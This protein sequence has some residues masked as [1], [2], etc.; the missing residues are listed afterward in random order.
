M[1]FGVE[2]QDIL[3]VSHKFRA[4]LGE[5]APLL[6]LPR[7]ESVFLRRFRIPSWDME[8]ASPN[9]TTFPANRRKVQ[10]LC[11]SGAGRHLQD[12]AGA[13][14]QDFAHRMRWLVR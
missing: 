8:D 11:P 14:M 9:S 13:Q 5:N 6:L 7:L 3:H 4:H 2:I 12:R 10:W 1:R